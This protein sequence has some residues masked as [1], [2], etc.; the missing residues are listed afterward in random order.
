M[1]QPKAESLNLIANLADSSRLHPNV[2]RL[3]WHARKAWRFDLHDT[4]SAAGGCVDDMQ[5]LR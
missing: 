4:R 3:E 1:T 5:Q 2:A